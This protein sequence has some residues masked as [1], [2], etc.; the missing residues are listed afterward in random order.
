M[1]T[2][3]I[4]VPCTLTLSR[5]SCQP[6]ENVFEA[7]EALCWCDYDEPSTTASPNSNNYNSRKTQQEQQQK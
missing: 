1:E 2:A 4:E 3:A 7:C 5:V 6:K